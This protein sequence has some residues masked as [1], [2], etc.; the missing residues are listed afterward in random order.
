MEEKICKICGRK[1][2]VMGLDVLERCVSCIDELEKYKKNR[3][4]F[5]RRWN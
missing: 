4:R 1:Y 3:C 5:W 2:I